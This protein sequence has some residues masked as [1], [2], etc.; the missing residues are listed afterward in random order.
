MNSG[1]VNIKRSNLRC[2]CDRHISMELIAVARVEGTCMHR[3]V[4]WVLVLGRRPGCQRVFYCRPSP[5]WVPPTGGSGPE[6][7]PS[8]GPGNQSETSCS[9]VY[10]CRQRASLVSRRSTTPDEGRR[11]PVPTWQGSEAGGSSAKL[12]K[13]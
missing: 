6:K 5:P 3:P 1:H 10:R 13:S 8:P 11:L 12:L 2:H 4:Q 9:P 7:P